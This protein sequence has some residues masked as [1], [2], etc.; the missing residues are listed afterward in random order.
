[1]KTKLHFLLIAVLFSFS[2]VFAAKPT[3]TAKS[4]T[5]VYP[6]VSLIGSGVGGWGV[7]KDLTTTDGVVYT[8]SNFE[9]IPGEVKFRLNHRWHDQAPDLAYPSPVP[10]VDQDDWGYNAASTYVPIGFPEDDGTSAVASPSAVIKNIPS[11]PGFWNVTF[12]LVTKHY[13]FTPGVNPNRAVVIN[14]GGLA[15]D[16]VLS[17]G[18]GINYS[19]E[20]VSFSTGGP[21]KFLEVASPINPAPTANWSSASFPGGTGTQDGALI[22]V[23]PGVYYTFFNITTGAYSFDP[24]TVSMI[25]SMNGWN[26][27]SGAWDMLT[28]DNVTFYLNNITLSSAGDFKFRDNH[29]WNYNYGGTSFPSGTG[30][31]NGGTNIAYPAGV[32]NV[33]FNR[34]TLVYTFVSLNANIQF[35]GTNVA[36]SPVGLGTADGTNYVAQHVI[37]G[38]GAG[39]GS[40]DEVASVLN[41]GPTFGTWPV[42]AT[43][44]G[45]LT[46]D[47]ARDVLFNKS[48]GVYSF[49]YVT[50]GITGS[51]NGWGGNIDL[52]T[53]DGITYTLSNL[54]IASA[55]D[56]KIRE[57]HSWSYKNYGDTANPAGLTGTAVHEGT[58]FHLEPGTYNV[59][60]NRSTLA[61]SF[62]TL[63]VNKF[64]ANKFSVYPNPT[65]NSWN[66]TSGN[67][68]IS[69]VKIID[70]LGKTVMSK[71]TA[72]KEV[73]VDASSLSK[74]MYFAKITSG[75]SVQT[76][77]VIR[78]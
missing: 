56:F 57:G 33:T 76:V 45:A 17:T 73:T 44:D 23:A 54:V 12:N 65:K 7:D 16:A 42:A 37:F 26:D 19:K 35:T 21:A 27:G 38:A 52:A 53:T 75:D 13:I 3:V 66:F 15:A 51:M 41:P 8:L 6:I 32:Y 31:F 64:D 24:T 22:P 55:S 4:T 78:D 2:S 34:I 11:T 9:I 36:A 62:A 68:D 10:G 25:G 58:N 29:S 63:A 40:F 67:S 74:G 60:F 20:S 77:K 50:Y 71:N 46:P 39:T 72:A 1:M 18:D 43:P 14:G 28:D 69:S 30:V 48:T 61:F 59:T 5:V 49:P 47:G 70:M